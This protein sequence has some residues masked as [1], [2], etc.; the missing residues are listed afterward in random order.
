MFIQ[1][2]LKLKLTP[3]FSVY[4]SVLRRLKSRERR[5]ASYPNHFIFNLMTGHSFPMLADVCSEKRP[6]K[7]FM[8][9]SINCNV[10]STFLYKFILVTNTQSI[11]QNNTVKPV[12][13]G[14]FIKWNFDLNGNIFRSCDYYSIP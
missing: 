8:I 10:I 7:S 14:P 6:A 13:N 3:Q 5:C 2:Y 9:P 1:L 12:L 11:P 4:C